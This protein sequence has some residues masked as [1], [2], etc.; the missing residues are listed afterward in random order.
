LYQFLSTG[1]LDIYQIV[2]ISVL[3]VFY[4]ASKKYIRDIET[5][6]S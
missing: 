1:V 4:I 6:S 2:F 3:I 5:T